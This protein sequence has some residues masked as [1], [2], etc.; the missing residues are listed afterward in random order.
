MTPDPVARAAARDSTALADRAIDRAAGAR[1]IP[2]NQVSL[3]IDGPNAFRAMFA[4][5]EQAEHRIHFEN[6]IIRDDRIGTE[7]AAAL[8]AK[9][10]SGIEVRVLYDW[11]GSIGTSGKYWRALRNAGA[12]VRSFNPPRAVDLFANLTRDHRKFVSADGRHAILGG[13]CIG[14]EWTGYP[15]RGV[16]PWRDTAVE[17]RGPAT[18]GL[19]QGFS[20]VWRRAG[21]RSFDEILHAS[22]ESSGDAAVRVLAGVP[23]R[24]RTYRV[25]ELLAAS[26][27]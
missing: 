14:D 25:L 7:F 20:R 2:G 9:A 22:G 27:A 4:L 6:Y 17:I 5:I 19:D 24:E 1:P 26:C 11:L 23:G 13:L 3:L 18:V 12:E 16:Q 21:G 10:R 15:E 8:A